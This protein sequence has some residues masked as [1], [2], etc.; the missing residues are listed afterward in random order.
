MRLFAPG[1]VLAIWAVWTWKTGDDDLVVLGLVVTAVA[2][3]VAERERR[4]QQRRWDD[5]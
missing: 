1:V 3:V 5:R 4:R 2:T